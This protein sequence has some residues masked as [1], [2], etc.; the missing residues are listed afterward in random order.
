MRIIRIAGALIISFILPEFVGASPS[1]DAGA[2]GERIS[3]EKTGIVQFPKGDGTDMITVRLHQR[4]PDYGDI[5]FEP[6]VPV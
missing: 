5:R 3:N 1:G 6:D 4:I 2:G